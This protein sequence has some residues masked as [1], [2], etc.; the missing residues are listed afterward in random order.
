MTNDEMIQAAVQEFGKLSPEELEV[1]QGHLGTHNREELAQRVVADATELWA[2]AHESG[3]EPKDWVRE[4]IN[5]TI[6]L[7][8]DQRQA[9]EM[10]QF[11]DDAMAFVD[12]LGAEARALLL[13]ILG[14]TQRTR[15][16]FIV[17]K[18]ARDAISAEL[19]NGNDRKAA[20][21]RTLKVHLEAHIE[22]VDANYF[23]DL[24]RVSATE[25]NPQ[26]ETK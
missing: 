7:L 6:D 2:P 16:A 18:L 13:A 1:L 8:H 5:V 20:I 9:F 10:T 22:D 17:A 14:T 23:A 24:R 15:V 4:Y 26:G 21:E 19:V 12:G 3:V 11:R 25:R